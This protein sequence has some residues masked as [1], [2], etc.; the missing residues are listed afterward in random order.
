M[1]TF[2][3]TKRGRIFLIQNLIASSE[4]IDEE[5]MLQSSLARRVEFIS[6]VEALTSFCFYKMKILDV[7]C[8]TGIYSLYFLKKG[9]M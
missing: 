9:Q 7:G 4:E 5:H 8:G 6:T 2:L 3:L 1:N